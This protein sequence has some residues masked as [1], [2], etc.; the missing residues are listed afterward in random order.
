[1]FD[2]CCRRRTDR[3]QDTRQGT[4]NRGASSYA[5]YTFHCSERQAVVQSNYGSGY[6]G[7]RLIDT[8]RSG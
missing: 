8:E 3:S 7:D 5:A 1:M 2:E 6:P 4:W